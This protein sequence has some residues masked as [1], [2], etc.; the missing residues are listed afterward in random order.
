MTKTHSPINEKRL[1]VVTKCLIDLSPWSD[2]RLVV[3]VAVCKDEA[4]PIFHQHLP[5]E[6]GPLVV[7]SH[8]HPVG[9]PISSPCFSLCLFF[10]VNL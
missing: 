7:E 6:L 10:D 5:Q 2:D 1:R 4:I 3:H 8:S 9:D